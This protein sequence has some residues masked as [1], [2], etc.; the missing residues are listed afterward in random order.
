MA[1]WGEQPTTS[2]QATEQSTDRLEDTQH[3]LA[4]ARRRLLGAVILLVLACALIPWMLDSTPRAW[5]DDV[6]LRMPKNEQP[7]QAKPNPSNPS[8]PS[9]SAKPIVESKP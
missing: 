7:Y 8:V 9:N 5:G 1:F 6:I 4:Q 2:T 3:A